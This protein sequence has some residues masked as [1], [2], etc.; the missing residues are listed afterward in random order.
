MRKSTLPALVGLFGLLLALSFGGGTAA[1]ATTGATSAQQTLACPSGMAQLSTWGAIQGASQ[2]GTAS[3]DFTVAADCNVQLSLVSYQAPAATFSEDTASQQTIFDTATATLAAG[4]HTLSVDV[5]NCFFQVDFILGS[6][7]ATLGPAGSSNF[8][9]A[10]GRLISAMNGGTA[11]CSAGTTDTGGSTDTTNTGSTGNQIP[12]TVTVTPTV[13]V[14]PAGPITWAPGFG[15]NGAVASVQTAPTTTA[16]NTNTGAVLGNQTAPVSVANLPSTS[17][18]G[19]DNNGIR[20]LGIA[21]VALGLVLL[22]LGRPV[23]AEGRLD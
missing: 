20:L 8:Y 15:P 2:G 16:T 17:T 9:S 4:A 14:I 21:A 18:D 1:A 6:P 7:I 19:G 22:R 12:V 23:Q 5:P 13:T 11:Q 3:V 10:Q